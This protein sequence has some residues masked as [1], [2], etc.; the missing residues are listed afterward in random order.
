MEHEDPKTA[1]S[2][3]KAD[4]VSNMHFCDLFFYHKSLDDAID[5][6]KGIEDFKWRHDL[7]KYTNQGM[8]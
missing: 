4:A 6:A 2:Y 1:P 5:A 3:K 7:R 8:Y